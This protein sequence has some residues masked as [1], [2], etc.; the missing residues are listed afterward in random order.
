[1]PKDLHLGLR[2]PEERDTVQRLRPVILVVHSSSPRLRQRL[3]EEIEGWCDGSIEVIGLKLSE[4]DGVLAKPWFKRLAALV[5]E[6]TI[7]EKAEEHL[8]RKVR[9][10]ND[11]AEV[12]AL[13]GPHHFQSNMDAGVF[14]SPE[15]ERACEE[16]IE[17]LFFD[18]RPNQ[19][20]LWIRG[21]STSARAARLRWFL[22]VNGV[23]YHWE[24]SDGDDIGVK[25]RRKDKEVEPTISEL[26]NGLGIIRKPSRP[27]GHPYDL[28]VVG[29]GPAG[30]SAA[31]SAGANGFSTLIIEG[32]N[33]GGDAVTSINLIENYLGFPGG[34]SGTK[35]L[36]LAIRQAD[37][38]DVD[39]LLGVRAAAL[40]PSP[41]DAHRFII[42]TNSGNGNAEVSAGM[43]LLACGQRHRPIFSDQ[44]SPG[45]ASERQFTAAGCVQYGMEKC[46]AV[47]AKNK[48]VLIVGGGDS[49]GQAALLLMRSGATS[50]TIITK[51]LDMAHALQVSI[52]AADGITIKPPPLTVDKYIGH[53][54][55]LTHV[56][57]SSG[58]EIP[59]GKVFVL[60]GGVPDTDWLKES[61]SDEDASGQRLN[62]PLKDGYIPTDAYLDPSSALMFT[63]S[64]PGVFAAGDARFASHRRVGQAVGQGV[65]AVASMELYLQHNWRDVLK[66]ETSQAWISR[67]VLRKAGL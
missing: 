38:L 48:K 54:N 10:Y 36:K 16:L 6:P 43:V 29:A 3:V 33:P 47:T 30:L 67:D 63:T 21:S 62:I 24:N 56:K 31:V 12:A 9:A 22:F 59:A 34:I 32:E 28:V 45:A 1:M 2:E 5:F 65:A 14:S 57:V 40:R 26:C 55:T 61:D 25:F 42:D 51:K 66:D 18:W 15:S 8:R 46:D 4:L 23:P 11:H 41:I 50:V 39:I 27:E 53:G 58:E 20:R 13:P 52:N 49:A 7:T 37:Q 19:P 60:A 35:L 44:N 64:I 17:R